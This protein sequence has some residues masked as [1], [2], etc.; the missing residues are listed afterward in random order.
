VLPHPQS[1]EEGEGKERKRGAKR[2]K[3]K[4]RQEASMVGHM[5]CVCLFVSIKCSQ[6]VKQK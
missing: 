1:E 4:W 6:L 5:Y 2:E 3:E